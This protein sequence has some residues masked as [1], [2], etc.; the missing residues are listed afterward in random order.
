MS[1]KR[2]PIQNI[3]GSDTSSLDENLIVELE[4]GET[5]VNT[6]VYENPEEVEE[7]TNDA[8]SETVDEAG[9]TPATEIDCTVM[10]NEVISETV[11]TPELSH[12]CKDESSVVDVHPTEAQETI[13]ESKT[14]NIPTF[15]LGQK[16]M[17]NPDAMKDYNGFKL[18]TFAYRNVYVI[19]KI[20]NKRVIITSGTYM[21]AMKIDD[22]FVANS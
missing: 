12:P 3:D 10:E 21:L 6:L 9:E 15:R 18:P 2:R 20:L 14:V 19:K 5:S 11:E 8:I 7:I 16:V 22:I 4:D 1:K 17:I 13:H